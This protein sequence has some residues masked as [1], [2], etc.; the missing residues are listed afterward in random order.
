MVFW[1][2]KSRRKKTG[3][4]LKKSHKKKKYERGGY[5][6]PTKLGKTNIKL[7]RV[8]GGG[9]K[10]K[11]VSADEIN[12]NNK[13]YKITKFVENKANFRYDRSKI[14]TKGAILMTEK[15]KVKVTSRP[16]QN[17]VLNGIFID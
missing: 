4:R 14:I 7:N 12:V 17:G 8:R 15:G 13:K 1:H 5:F 9:M 16:G 2:L 6:I 3:G 11:L 10:F